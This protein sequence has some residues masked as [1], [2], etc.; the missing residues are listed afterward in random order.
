MECLL[1]NHQCDEE[2]LNQRLLDKQTGCG[3]AA[4]DSEH[5]LLS[6]TQTTVP[7]SVSVTTQHHSTVS[8]CY[9]TLANPDCKNVSLFLPSVVFCTLHPL[10][11]FVHVQPFVLKPWLRQ[12]KITKDNKTDTHAI[13]RSSGTAKN[14][15]FLK[16]SSTDIKLLTIA[17]FL[18]SVLRH[19]S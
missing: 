4:P 6:V 15:Q 19:T 12:G 7:E 11:F 14:K 9:V 16:M 3:G 5:P 17:Q 8:Q 2:S 13:S 1:V 18:L 10:I